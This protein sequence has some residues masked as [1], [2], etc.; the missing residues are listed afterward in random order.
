MASGGSTG[1]LVN[2]EAPSLQDSNNRGAIHGCTTPSR[3]TIECMILLIE[4]RILHAE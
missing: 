4:P 1:L 2:Q 3:A